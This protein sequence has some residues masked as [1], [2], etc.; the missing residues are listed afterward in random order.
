[1]PFALL[2][3]TL[4]LTAPARNLHSAVCD[5]AQVLVQG[6]AYLTGANPRTTLVR[7]FNE[8]GILDIAVGAANASGGAGQV[9]IFIG[10]GS[11]GNGNGTFAKTGTFPVLARP[12]G[13]TSG[14]FNEDGILD[15]A[16]TNHVSNAVSI[17]IGQGASGVGNGTF[18]AAISYSVGPN[19]Y[20][21]AVADFNEDGIL[22]LVV[23]QNGASTLQILRGQGSGGVGNGTFLTSTSLS[24]ANIPLSVVTGDFNEDGHAD[25]AATVNYNG[26]VAV[27]LGIGNGLFQSA[28]NYAAGNEPYDLLATD[29][30][31]DGITD[32]VVGNGNTGGVAVLRGGGSG[33]VG[34]GTFLPPMIKASGQLNVGSVVVADFD[35]DGTLDVLAAYSVGNG[36][37]FLR[38]LGG[39]ALDNPVQIP[40]ATGL[41]PIGMSVADFDNDGDLDVSV[42]NYNGPSG[43][44]LSIL[45][46]TCGSAPPGPSPILDDVR[47]VPNDEGGRVFVVWQRSPLDGL[48]GTTVTGYRVWR[49]I[50]PAIAAARA[51]LPGAPASVVRSRTLADRSGAALITYWEAVAQLPAQRLEGYGYTAST[52]QDSMRHSNP[53]TAFFIT[54]L[55]ADPNVFYDSAVD[56]GYSV[57]NLPPGAPRSVAG[58]YKAGEGFELTWEPATETDVLEYRV[59]RGTTPEFEPSESNLVATVVEALYR[60]ADAVGQY[61]YRLAA[62][63]EH[64]N[65]GPYAQLEPSETVG[66]DPAGD[67]VFALDGI[68]PN[69]SRGG[70]MRISFALDREGPVTLRLIDLTGR[71]VAS[72]SGTFAPGSHSVEMESGPRLSPGIYFASLEQ[73]GRVARMKVT[74]L[75]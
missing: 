9:D 18:A 44:R 35:L 45:L 63:D 5:P 17:L 69:P 65:I 1:L 53:Y 62:V 60:D 3:A 67:L 34:N 30:D 64:E 19:P 22:D 11:G 50:P 49:R 66:V 7:D 2:L 36:I 31:Q 25:I 70:P 26:Q 73:A 32:L 55:T 52:T 14:D 16:V 8:D 24:V 46:G 13:M 39:G 6:A 38:G 10:Q 27:F 58:I 47:D 74:V 61:Y 15:L 56:S 57:D 71:E 43:S 75:R 72:R 59:H 48:T 12:F 37:Y 54:A 41:F 33:G 29:F 51:G 28:V 23:A 40:Q 42:A 4:M 21:I 68:R 20:G